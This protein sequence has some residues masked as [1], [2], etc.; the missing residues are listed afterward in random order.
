MKKSVL[1]ITAQEIGSRIMPP[2]LTKAEVRRGSL[3]FEGT[4]QEHLVDTDKHYGNIGHGAVLKY[5]RKKLLPP[6]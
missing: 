4:S 5:L 6:H 1:I 3:S 2:W